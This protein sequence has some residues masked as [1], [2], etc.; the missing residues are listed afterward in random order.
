MVKKYKQLFRTRQTKTLNSS[1]VNEVSRKIES[2]N[3]VTE[4]LA[5]RKKYFPNVNF[6]LPGNF[7]RFGSAEE[8]YK[9]SIENIYKSYPY[10]GSL[11]E[12]YE[13]HLCT[14]ALKAK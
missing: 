9:K 6:S 4:F 5:D 3:Y 14:R 7:A 13:W 11:K 1:S 8:Y 10:D 12:K 2:P